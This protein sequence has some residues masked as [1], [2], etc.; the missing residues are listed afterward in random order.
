V[1]VCLCPCGFNNHRNTLKVKAATIVIHTLADYSV[2]LKDR[3]HTQGPWTLG[4]ALPVMRSKVEGARRQ[5]AEVT[6]VI[7]GGR[8]RSGLMII[9]PGANEAQGS[10][11]LRR[12]RNHPMAEATSG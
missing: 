11:D 1:L 7:R 10:E 8:R 3:Q 6:R 4:Q 9:Q 12:M 2:W 5:W